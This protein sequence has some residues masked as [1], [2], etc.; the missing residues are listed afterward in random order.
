MKI[1]LPANLNIPEKLYPLI[2]EL[3]NYTYFIIKGGRGGAKSQSVGR[4][5]LYIAENNKCRIVCGREIQNTIQ[6]SVYSLLS[7]HIRDNSLNFTVQ[8]SKIMHNYSGTEFTF[9][10]FRQ[11]GSFNVQ[12]MEG[13]DIVWIDEAQ[14]I[15]KETLDR[16]TPTLRKNTSKFIFTMNPHVVNDPV[17]A[18]FEGRPDCLVIEIN[19]MDNPHC[20]EKLLRDAEHCKK[21]SIE[22]YNHI[23]LGIPLAQAENA[24]YSLEELLHTRHY[25][26]NLAPG[27][28][29]R[30][31]GFDV[32]RF[33]D[34]KCAVVI[35]QQ[36]GALHWE[37]LHVDEW[38]KMDTVYS[39]ARFL[40]ILSQYDVTKAIIDEDGIGGPMLDN[41]NKDRHELK[42]IVGFRNPNLSYKDN[43]DY[44]NPRTVNAYKIKD[45]ICKGHLC[46]PQEDLIKEG[47]TVRY[48]YDNYQRK[49]LVPKDVM[50]DKYKVKSP[51]QWDALTMAASLIGTV[52]AEQSR[53]YIAN[54]NMVAPD[55]NLFTDAGIR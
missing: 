26:H 21:K 15:T 12:G 17:V 38:G 3:N 5:L 43:Q 2:L 47:T 53:P 1:E 20:T 41:I 7:D 45:M 10:G 34:D 51:N 6:E 31:A 37:V 18:E 49:L 33:G 9:R 30:L 8:S 50:K 13:V 52:T 32:A 28:G 22:D 19:Y 48:M 54:R 11:Q 55:V 24:L 14:A 42:K 25:H 35:L 36:M 16:L 23:W 46:I 39:T 29:I 4:A 40:Q 44:G 27:F